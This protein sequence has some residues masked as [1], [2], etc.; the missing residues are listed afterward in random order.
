ML[1]PVSKHQNSKGDH[2]RTIQGRLNHYGA[3]LSVDGVFGSKTDAAVRAFQAQHKLEVDGIV[4]PK[5]WA[6][7]SGGSVDPKPTSASVKA[8]LGRA[9]GELGNG[10]Q[11]SGSNRTK[12]GEWYGANG[13]PWCAMFVSWVFAH[14]G[15]PLSFT[16]KKGFAYCPSGMAGFKARG[17]WH[18]SGPRPG[19]VVFFN[20][21]GGRVDHVGIVESVNKDGSITTIEGN[22]SHNKV[23]HRHRSGKTIAGYGRPNYK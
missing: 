13:H 19:D 11:P 2:V 18:V 6:A 23:E 8:I 10:E 4:G 12:Y 21:D 20:W 9:R 1:L 14:E 17:Q 5:T 22:T 7:L 15:M 16:T 3:H